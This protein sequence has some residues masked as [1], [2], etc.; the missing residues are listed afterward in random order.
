MNDLTHV[1]VICPGCN[2]KVL[3]ADFQLSIEHCDD[4]EVGASLA[5]QE[6][7]EISEA[8]AEEMAHYYGE[9]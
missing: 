9:A 3:L 4:C 1:A 2:S 7:H 6:Q 5:M 8:E